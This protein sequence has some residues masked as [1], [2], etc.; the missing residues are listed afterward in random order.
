MSLEG[1][2]DES[3]ALYTRGQMETSFDCYDM[4]KVV[5]DLSNLSFMDSTGIGVLIGRFKKLKERGVT[6]VIAN[7]SRSI[8]KILTLSGVYTLM[9][10][11]EY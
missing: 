1:E 9:P 10:K 8:D 5:I 6:V 4:G 11:V 3:K 2:L 7:P